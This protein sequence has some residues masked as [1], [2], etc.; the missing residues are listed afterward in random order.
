[1]TGARQTK[2]SQTYAAA[3]PSSG[4]AAGQQRHLAVVAGAAREHDVRPVGAAHD[5]DE[6]VKAGA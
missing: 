3:L 2:P 1:M 4:D 6:L 5:R